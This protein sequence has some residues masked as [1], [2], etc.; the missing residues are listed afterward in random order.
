[1]FNW[2]YRKKKKGVKSKPSTGTRK[3]ADPV[4]KLDRVFS[5]YIRLRDTMPSGVFRCI[6]C[7]QIKPFQQGDCGHYFSRTHMATRWDGD[8]AHMECSYCNRVRSDHLIGY[9]ANLLAKI[10]PER[11]RVLEMKASSTKHWLDF[12]LQE[13]IDYFTAE[14]RRLSAEKGIKVKI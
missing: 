11:M 4:K 10:G 13:M 6:S 14:V 7:G 5:A 2:Y 12:E 8:N 9:R 1:M 3:N